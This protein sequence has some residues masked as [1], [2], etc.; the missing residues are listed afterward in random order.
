MKNYKNKARCSLMMLSAILFVSMKVY[1]QEDVVEKFVKV[2]PVNKS[3]VLSIH[4]KYGNIDVRDWEKKEIKI[5]AEIIVRN[6]SS[7]KAKQVL[8]NVTIDFS[9]EGDAINIQTK[10]N[11]AFFRIV[12]HNHHMNNKKFEV[13]YVVTMPPSVKIVLENKYGNIFIN[14]LKS[15]ST[16]TLKYGNLQINQLFATGK[17]K[18]AELFLAYS[19]AA[20]EECQWLKMESKYSKVDMQSAKALIVLSKYSKLNIENASS[21]VSESKY[22][23]YHVGTLVNFVTNAQYSH[24]RFDKLMKKLSLD[25]KYTDTKIAFVPSAFE[26]IE[27]ENSY[28]SISI[29]IDPEA[30]YRLQGHA[31]YAKIHY[32]SDSKV[33]RFQEN[34][35]LSVKGV[36]GT[37]KDNLPTVKI[38]T[39]YGSINLVK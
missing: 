35:E 28:G 10:F 38:E 23:T 25:T 27:I 17:D 37:K 31:K 20:I 33:N 2:Y 21:I 34:T 30:S 22:D 5:N 8:D 7:Q 15:Q 32:P 9:Q 12:G 18:M 16:I 39:K 26:S 1:A 24:F 6:L 13:N 11:D 19:K 36:V 3:T 29:G 14:K 4:T